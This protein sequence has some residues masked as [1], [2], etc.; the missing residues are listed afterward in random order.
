[1]N[2]IEIPYMD[3]NK[4]N[5]LLKGILIG[6]AA[7]GGTLLAAELF[8]AFSKPITVYRCPN[9]DGAISAKKRGIKNCP[10][11]NIDLEWE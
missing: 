2:T 5:T 3:D 9:C 8:K 1:M 11:C 10:Y 6:L 7:I 4:N